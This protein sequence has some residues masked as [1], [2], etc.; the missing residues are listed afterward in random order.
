M[1][2]FSW[3]GRP[4]NRG[5]AYH[6]FLH[7]KPTDRHQ[8]LHFTSSHPNHTK[9][10]IVYS[11]ALRV[12]RIYSRECNFRK[13]I[14]EMKAWFLRKGCPKNFVES[15]IKKVKFSRV[16]KNKSQK[17]TLKRTPLVV[18]YHPLLNSLGKKLSKN[19][20]ILYMDEEAKKVFYPG[21]TVSFRSAR[22]VS[23][24]LVRA[25]VYHLEKTV[26]SFKCKKSRC[27][28]CL[29]VNETDTFTSTVTKKTYKIN[30]KFD[31]SDKCLIYLLTCKKCLIQYVGKV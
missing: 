30:H 16:S 10:S 19:L 9:R 28:V 22:K 27:Q 3:F 1:S 7:I 20:N 2:P 24:Y 8:Y 21:P 31:C 26:G 5:W 18:T 15:E 6:K 23:N 17:R 25:K 14:S 12:S 13:H 29:N 4:I 11:P